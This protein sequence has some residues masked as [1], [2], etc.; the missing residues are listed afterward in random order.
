[1][2]DLNP[3]NQER[4]ENQDSSL[5]DMSGQFAR[6]SYST[7]TESRPGFKEALKNRILGARQQVFMQKSKLRSMFAGTPAKF[8]VIGTPVL[9]VLIIAIMV[10]QPF[11]GVKEV[12]AQDNFTL[13]AEQV[14][15]L[16]I[17]AGSSFLLESKEPMSVDD[18]KDQISAS[19]DTEFNL[20]QIS[21][22]QIRIEFEKDLNDKELIQF[23]LN[24]Q[25]LS[26]NGE[27]M[28]RPYAWAF[29]V[30][31]KF[32]ITGTLPG[33]QKTGVPLDAG[34]EVQFSN[35][36]VNEKEFEKAF[37]INPSVSGH[38]EKFRNVLV[39]VPEKLDKETL[40]T[41]T[42]DKTL[43]VVGS[44]E[45]LPEDYLFVFETVGA[46]RQ[47]YR[48]DW[49]QVLDR[50][51][52][53][54]P[55][56][57]PMVQFSY[58]SSNREKEVP[59]TAQIT[60]HKFRTFDDYVSAQKKADKFAWRAY[61]SMKDMVDFSALDS[62][63]AFSVDRV[64]YSYSTFLLF[65]QGIP[66]GNYF[67]EVQYANQSSWFLLTSTDLIAYLAQGEDKTLVWVNSTK[68]KLPAEGAQVYYVDSQTKSLSG[69]DGISYLESSEE[70]YIVVEFQDEK[71][72]L[73]TLGGNLY[74]R[75]TSGETNYWKY[76][77][78]DR[79]AYKSDDTVYFWGFLE[80]RI[81]KES[82][83]KVYAELVKNNYCSRFGCSTS[84][85]NRVYASEEIIMSQG[86][87]YSGSFDLP[88]VK[89]GSYNINIKIEDK[90]VDSGYVYVDEYVKPAYELSVNTDKDAYF[91]DEEVQ[92]TVHGQYFEGTPTKGLRVKVSTGY[93]GPEQE[94]TLDSAGNGQGK[95]VADLFSGSYYSASKNTRLIVTPVLAEEADMTAE[96]SIKVFDTR[97][98]IGAEAELKES[99]A[100][101]DISTKSIVP[102]MSYLAD[103]FAPV[104]RGNQLVTG[105]IQQIVYRKE[106]TGSVYDFIRKYTVKQY[107]YVR[108]E[109]NVGEFSL[110]TD[111]YGKAQYSFEASNP[112]AH[113]RVYL[114]ARDE[115]GKN[116]STSAYV[117]RNN[118]PKNGGSTTVDLSFH[119]DTGINDEATRYAVGDNVGLSVVQGEEE[120]KAQTN[121]TFLF[122]QAQQGV[123]ETA[124]TKSPKYTFD[125]EER[126]IPNIQVFGVLFTGNGYAKIK[127]NGYW[128]GG[129]GYN[130]GVELD[131]RK[132]DI[133]IN[134][135][136]SVYKPGE[137][138]KASVFVK[139][140][141]NNPIKADVNVK[142]VDEAYYKIYPSEPNPIEVLYQSLSSGITKTQVSR[143][144]VTFLSMGAE[145]GGGGGDVRSVFE[146]T[147][148]VQT[149]QT[150]SN[151]KAEIELKLP[152][153]VT[154]WRLTTQAIEKQRK[155]AGVENVNIDATI[156]FFVQPTLRDVYLIGDS[157]VILLRSA[158]TDLNASDLVE[159]EVEIVGTEQLLKTS[160][161]ANETASVNLPKL[162]KG[163]YEIL[164][165]GKSGNFSDIIQRPVRIVESWLTSPIIQEYDL[166]SSSKIAGAETG[167][168]T[169]KFINGG[170]GQFY[171]DVMRLARGWG[172]LRADEVAS[173]AMGEK[174]L[175]EYF[176]EEKQ[177]ISV[178]VENYQDQGIHLLPFAEDELE[179]TA[180][181][182]MLRDTPFDEKDMVAYLNRHLYDEKETGRVL[183]VKTVALVY[184][185]LAALGE[186][187]L[188]EIQWMS[189]R[190]DLGQEEKLMIAL[191]LYFAGDLEN[192]RVLY[193]ELVEV[194]EKGS[195]YRFISADD[196]ETKAEQ[197]ALMA[198]LSGGLQ[199]EQRDEFYGYIETQKH[200]NTLLV[201][202]KAVFLHETLP[203]L[204]DETARVSYSLN[205]KRES[206]ELK[207]R[208]CVSIDVSQSELE[209]LNP[210]VESGSVIAIANYD[211]PV[212]SPGS[213]TDNRLSVTRGYYSNDQQ[214]N[215]FGQSDLIKVEIKYTIS[216]SLP[217]G[218]YQLTDILPSGLTPVTTWSRTRGSSQNYNCIRYPYNTE[219]QK[220]SFDIYHSNT[221]DNV[222][223]GQLFYYAR[224]VTPGEYKA[225]SA[226]LRSSKD[227]TQFNYARTSNISIKE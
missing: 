15:S 53:S 97:V 101:V 68:T 55:D 203:T 170:Q 151:G 191:A 40:Y 126:D 162:E 13:T 118:L 209:D 217:N 107:R 220:V 39:F 54:A 36:N 204:S 12:Y 150:G 3:N 95:F 75:S 189:K 78:T 71:I 81:T 10:F 145:G 201:V 197:T 49:F 214:T 2:T 181:I 156:P 200:G 6:V 213:D 30:K 152:D 224:V 92:F 9:V 32:Q 149:V 153:N 85:S 16:G 184:A 166:S 21:D 129:E 25:T 57:A 193:R 56:E 63:P 58:Y 43:G 109:T 113:Y 199:E 221:Y 115:F 77:T 41:V 94:I 42:I 72:L 5:K 137:D 8:A 146:D 225:E 114:D 34:I 216:D 183:D 1:M 33:N 27:A 66:Q 11:V 186:P 106:E 116:Y 218:T 24:S 98:Y 136:K 48:Q 192:A 215:I 180:R 22:T 194:S 138:V 28:A 133:E 188:S 163:N 26:P 168:T 134:L 169:V 61:A 178:M 132:L 161:K 127:G 60:L 223:K 17:E 84:E 210:V 205:G 142:V 105:R 62:S 128:W 124:I 143:E 102:S 182:A 165:S 112:E 212:A 147:A 202:E 172:G 88:S 179:L 208:R 65:P 93:K 50:N 91:Y 195:G 76:I 104:P 99:Q 167:W 64:E 176:N 160:A 69:E 120:Y 227:P 103:D 79:S 154:Q 148:F 111:A 83:E 52:S 59:P 198:I 206:V 123:Q 219:G 141:E 100:T 175:E 46:S 87:T 20:D 159:Y 174:I 89:Q 19:I 177:E 135:E 86:G 35:N 196:I 211:E 23:R 130:I 140:R 90:V 157:P 207:G 14:D 125:F 4:N 117:W 171:S 158:G 119:E 226:I 108:E 74:Y 185:G 70:E 67:V 96:K 122:F 173:R 144:D 164:I 82:P 190:D 222:C 73:T 18:I 187:V 110:T 29:Q 7:N 51:V 37:H 155:F 44:D 47:Q 121:D 131:S 80:N 139:D 45:E 31:S 38:V